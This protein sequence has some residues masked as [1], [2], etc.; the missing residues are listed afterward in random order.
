MPTSFP[1]AP[2]DFVYQSGRGTGKGSASDQQVRV[3]VR[4]AGHLDDALLERA[5]HALAGQ[6]PVL[7]CRFVETGVLEGRWEPRP[8]VDSLRLCEVAETADADAAVADFLTDLEVPEAGPHYR[9][10]LVRSGG[11]D[12]L[13]LRIDH[14][15]ADGAGAKAIAYLV[16]EL[17]RALRAGR[18]LPAPRPAF[19]PRTVAGLSGRPSPP[20]PPPEKASFR[21]PF[22]LPRLGFRNER[23]AHAQR[24]LDPGALA[25][26]RARGRRLGAT[27]NDLVLTALVR[28]L[29]PHCRDPG[30]P[31]A[32]DVSCDHRSVLPPQP[33]DPICNLF[34][35]LF[36]VL[37]CAP[38]EPFHA[39][40]ERVVTAMSALRATLTLDGALRAELAYE[41]LV[42]GWAREVGWPI[43]FGAREG[44]F[45][46]LS[47]LGVF[48]AARLDFGEPQ[49]TDARVL[50]TIALGQELLLCVSTFRDRLTLSH[51][52]CRS[53][54]EEAV[55]D[56]VMDGVMAEL[57]AFENAG[58]AAA[59][60]QGVGRSS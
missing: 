31:F 28:A 55:V 3:L 9:A 17:Y 39:T 60:R 27:V 29:L 10:R 15:L 1:A 26:L 36:P 56:R 6:D 52:Y 21:F 45:V 11:L 32:V 41:D 38:G 47:N 7:G 49:V 48:D 23:P 19:R 2:K 33:R 53:D 13:C 42:R 50:G 4:F 43:C 30:E 22:R 51:G 59:Q 24:E 18:A 25:R 46:I 35:V 20:R 12:A 37:R 57:A 8:D 44:T 16:A 5:L 58:E 14:R 34:G 54:V 40:L